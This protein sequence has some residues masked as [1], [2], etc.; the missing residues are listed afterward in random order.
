MSLGNAH[1]E[2]AVG[3]LLHG[4]VH[5][6]ARGHGRRDAHYA[7]VLA[8]QLEQ[9][10]AEHLLVLLR[11]AL[12]VALDELSRLGV[13]LPRRVPHGLVV[14]GGGVAVALLRVQVE[15][16]GA[17]HVLQLP[18]YAHQLLHVVAV[19]GAEVAYVHSLEYVL[20]AGDDALQRVHQ[21]YDALAPVFAEHTVLAHP[22]RG[23]EA[24]SVVGLVGVQ[25]EQVL[26]HASHGAV[27][28][29]VVVVEHDEHVVGALRHV[30]QPLE[31]QSA[32]HGAV[33]YDGHHFS[34]VRS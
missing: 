17:L 19:E 4:D 7:R 25:V 23:A 32:A 1:V 3:Q 26:L 8:C 10:V 29:H 27:Y 24:Q 21:A 20:L 34:G 13:E 12:L 11:A 15:Q 5:G 28:R 6:A 31:G 30:V 2:H 16:L 33:A 18:Q 14:L 9:R 22:L